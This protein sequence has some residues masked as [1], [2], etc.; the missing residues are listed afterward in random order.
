MNQLLD[1]VR[2][3]GEL[4]RRARALKPMLAGRILVADDDEHV[5]QLMVLVLE[6][7]GFSVH[8]VSDGEQAWA[9]LCVESYGLLITDLCM[10]LL[11]GLELVER[12]RAAGM[13]LP[14][15]L[16]SGTFISKQQR[17]DPRLQLTAVLEKPFDIRR[18]V[19]LANQALP[20][21]DQTVQASRDD[22]GSPVR[23]PVPMAAHRDVFPSRASAR[24][25]TQPSS[26]ARPTAA[27]ERA[28][29]PAPHEPAKQ[30]LLT[31]DDPG[32]RESL[33]AVLRGEGYTVLTAK[34]GQHALDI[35]SVAEVDLVLL[36]LNMPVK[37]GWDTFERLTTTHPLTPV[38]IIT[39][40]PYQAFTAINAGVG[41]L[42]EKPLDI[43]TLLSTI[44]ALLAESAEERMARLAGLNTSFHYN[45]G[46]GRET[47]GR[48]TP[49]VARHGGGEK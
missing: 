9:A 28:P 32:V 4:R 15:I 10:P 46:A 25:A 49:P 39:A 17:L 7:T 24:S 19:A 47:V 22:R 1:A 35:R 33:A 3:V 14:V 42:L 23:H 13:L 34:D 2:P 11:S 8:A 37:N 40:R 16:A 26:Q 30:I 43:P 12:V 31:D 44:Q 27:A 20:G 48:E 18:L 41:A 5:R 45:P 38:I 29:M 21:G 36:D 6:A